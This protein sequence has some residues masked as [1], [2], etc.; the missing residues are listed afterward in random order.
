MEILGGAKWRDD[1]NG[2]RT[3]ITVHHRS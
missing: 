1:C 2:S 3:G